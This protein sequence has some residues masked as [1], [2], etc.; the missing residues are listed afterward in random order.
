MGIFLQR[1]VL[2]VLIWAADAS[3][4]YCRLGT[5]IGGAV[6]SVQDKAA[7]AERSTRKKAGLALICAGSIKED[8]SCYSGDDVVQA[9][10]HLKGAPDA[11]LEQRGLG[12]DGGPCNIAAFGSLAHRQNCIFLAHDHLQWEKFKLLLRS[13]R[14]IISGN[15][16]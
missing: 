1:I 12:R 10:F 13:R 3:C 6:S 2:V 15:A 11:P 5:I 9:L 8:V 14:S 7:G 4:C 16:E